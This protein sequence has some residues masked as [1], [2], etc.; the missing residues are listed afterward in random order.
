MHTDTHFGKHFN[1]Y[2]FDYYYIIEKAFIPFG[3]LKTIKK[4]SV[5]PPKPPKDSNLCPCFMHPNTRYSFNLV[6]VF[7]SYSYLPLWI[8]PR[9]SC[10]LWT[11][12]PCKKPQSLS[13]SNKLAGI[14]VKKTECTSNAPA[15]VCL[16]LKKNVLQQLMITT[17]FCHF[18]I[19]K[20]EL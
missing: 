6:S 2:C 20:I 19:T 9:A 11:I 7:L 3:W 12:V 4:I 17:P 1:N 14:Y 8:V 15:T 16:Q 5:T 13:C 18:F 10:K